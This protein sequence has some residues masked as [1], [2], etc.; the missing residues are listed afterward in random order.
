MTTEDCGQQLAL[1]KILMLSVKIYDFVSQ[2]K[3]KERGVPLIFT[4]EH[5][6]P[7]FIVFSFSELLENI[8]DSLKNSCNK[9]V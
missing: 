4:S 8:S 9:I 5:S 2:F 6:L 7:L 3:Y 1:C